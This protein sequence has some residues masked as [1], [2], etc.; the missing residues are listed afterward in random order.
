VYNTGCLFLFRFEI[1]KITF[2]GFETIW[3][4]L[5]RG[6]AKSCL[7]GYRK[8]IVFSDKFVFTHENSSSGVLQ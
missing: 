4:F 8:G 2:L 6:A 7:K 1:E 5:I 3:G